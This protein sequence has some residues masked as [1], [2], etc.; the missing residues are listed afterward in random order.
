MTIMRKFDRLLQLIERLRSE[1]GCPWDREQTIS[2]L[3]ADLLSEAEEVAQAIDTEDYENLKEE[4]GD[5][6]WAAALITQI[7]H[8][9]EHF[10]MDDVLRQV[11][12]KMV[13][14]HPHVFGD[15]TATNAQEAKRI[16][17]DVK[18]G[19]KKKALL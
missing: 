7:A 15:V 2:S 4:I 11:N 8:E 1:A 10:D 14:R 12:E 9:E 6:I 18:K 13:R 3:K 19:E 16:F 17:Y 5:L